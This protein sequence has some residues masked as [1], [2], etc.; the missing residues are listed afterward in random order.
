VDPVPDPLLLRRK[1]SDSVLG[2]RE[3]GRRD[4]S[5][6]CDGTALLKEEEAEKEEKEKEE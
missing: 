3:Y 5:S 2:N 1:S 6:V 4:P